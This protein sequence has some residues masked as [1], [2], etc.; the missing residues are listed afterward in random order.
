MAF[1]ATLHLD[2]FLSPGRMRLPPPLDLCTPADADA[3]LARVADE[4]EAAVRREGEHAELHEDCV[5]PW[6]PDRNCFL[7]EGFRVARQVLTE[8][9]DCTLGMPLSTAPATPCCAA[10]ARAVTAAAEGPAGL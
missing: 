8:R 2:K 3:A 5:A 7:T 1:P 9:A 4:A 10:A 6:E